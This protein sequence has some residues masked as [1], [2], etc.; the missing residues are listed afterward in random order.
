MK[1]D[2]SMQGKAIR[3]KWVLASGITANASIIFLDVNKQQISIITKNVNNSIGNYDEVVTIPANTIWIAYSAVVNGYSYLYEI[4]PSNEPTFIATNG[5][6]LLTADPIN[7]IRLPYQMINI[8]YFASSVQKLY[9]IGTTGNWLNYS[10]QVIKLDQGQTI[11]AKG[12]DKNGIETRIISSY[13]VNVPDALKVEGFDNNV[14]T[15]TSVKTDQYMDVDPSMIGKTVKVKW[16]KG[17]G[18]PCISFLDSERVVISTFKRNSSSGGQTTY[19]DTYTV[20]L[21]T[22][23]LKYHTEVAYA[24]IK[25]FE[26]YP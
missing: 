12:I 11:Y 15:Y 25:L 19:T 4:Q 24:T 9:R 6:M 2:S 23:Y 8:S 3:L 20:P 18:I 13:T 17:E 7:S 5:Y 21:N 16:D 26:I 1:V 22:K 14:N 10:N